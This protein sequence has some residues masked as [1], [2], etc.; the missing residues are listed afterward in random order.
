MK[1]VVIAGGSG[2]IGTYLAKRFKR[3]GYK[4]F[5]V[6][7]APQHVSWNSVDLAEVLEDATLII[8]L[9][10]RSINC[11]HNEINRNEIINSRV[12]ATKAIGNAIR[13]CKNPP[14][15]WVNA[16]ATGIYKASGNQPMTEERTIFAND[17]LAEVVR[18]WEK[19]FFDFQLPQT[20]QVALRT[21]VVLGRNG[22]ALKP[23]ATLTRLGLGGK[24]GNGRQQFSWIHQED[25]F[26][27]LLFLIENQ[28]LNQV[29]NCTAPTPVSNNAL[30]YTLRKKL[31]VTIGIPAPEFAI[32][33]GAKLMGTE[34]DLILGSSMVV[35]KRLLDA[36][37]QFHYPTLDIALIDLLRTK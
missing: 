7:R 16:S 9:A 8:N 1:K 23:L 17:F 33:I 20:R 3:S 15:L 30:M 25:Y 10:G 12:I 32:R 6:S 22:G 27:I 37:F 31:K 18:E 2:F 35:P 34:P 5:I 13:E 24:Q 28:A 14:A 19:A 29:I 26:R 21:S 11:R 4:V 36:G